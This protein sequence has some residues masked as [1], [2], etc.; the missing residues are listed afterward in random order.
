MDKLQLARPCYAL[1]SSDG[2]TAVLTLY[3]EIVQK[4]PIDWSTG[5][6]SNDNFIVLNEFLKDLEAVADAKSV[7]VRIHSLGGD[8][9]AAIAIHNRLRELARAGVS[10]TGIVDGVAASGGSLILCACDTIKTNPSSLIMIHNC[11]AFFFGFYNANDLKQEAS[12]CEKW[13]AAQRAI[14]QRKTGLPEK[15]LK[16]MMSETTYFTGEEA[17]AKGFADE[18]LEDAEPLHIAASADKRC[19]FAHGRKLRVL[20]VPDD[21]P[22]VSADK[23]ANE[24]NQNQTKK[25]RQTM[26]N[27]NNQNQEKAEAVQTAAQEN[28]STQSNTEA[29]QTAVQ[30]ERQRL[31]QIDALANL[32][33][34]E[35]VRA[36]KYG[37]KACT[38]QEMTYRAA[39]EA[40]KQGKAFL[41]DLQKDAEESGVQNVQAAAP[42]PMNER[43][44]TPEQRRAQGRAAIRA[45]QKGE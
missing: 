38:A 29:V 6:P 13:D 4:R 39:L 24:N 19:L 26:P 11:A 27:E 41:T 36:A 22:V 21:L 34:A 42:S 32:Y 15:E 23:Q 10:L 20:Y 44:N 35:T 25:E 45:M 17:V 37:D 9:S 18:L 7:T 1:E 3:G 5:L 8:A 14:Y 31:Q 28:H 43:T 30:A 40:A 12:E 2:E 16:Q 33:D